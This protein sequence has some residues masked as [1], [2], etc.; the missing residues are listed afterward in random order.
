MFWRFNPHTTVIKMNGRLLMGIGLIHG[1]T[2]Q[3][4]E[5]NKS[6]SQM[7][8]FMAQFPELEF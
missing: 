2:H 1:K 7:V 5:Q 4:N 8:W 3:E 6:L